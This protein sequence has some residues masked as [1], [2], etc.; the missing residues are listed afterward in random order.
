MARLLFEVTSGEHIISFQ[1]KTD[2]WYPGYETNYLY[3]DNAAFGIDSDN[4]GI[5]NIRDNCPQ[6][7][8]RWQEDSD[9]DGIGDDCDAEPNVP[10]VDS[11]NDGIVDGIDNCP[12]IQNPTQGKP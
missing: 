2:Y 8:N 5:I 10:D 1:F 12:A 6:R 11:D 9:N 3:L 4:D 7:S